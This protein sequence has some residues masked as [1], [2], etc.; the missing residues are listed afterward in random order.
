MKQK[1]TLYSLIMRR[2]G[3][4]ARC[5]LPFFAAMV[6]FVLF[7]NFA[8]TMYW[9][10]ESQLTTVEVQVTAF[11]EDIRKTYGKHGG[12]LPVF[13]LTAENKEYEIPKGLFP[14]FDDKAFAQAYKEKRM[15]MQYRTPWFIPPQVCTLTDGETVYLSL[16]DFSAYERG[17]NRILWILI[18]VVFVVFLPLC[19]LNFYFKCKELPTIGKY[20]RKKRRRENPETD[21]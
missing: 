8:M 6:L 14:Y 4:A 12:S 10:D 2:V 1:Q 11:R 19:C 15:T 17:Q 21:R 20:L 7:L 13:I 5:F 16:E 9:G 18:A 3:L